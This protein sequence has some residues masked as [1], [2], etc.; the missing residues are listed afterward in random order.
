MS[1]VERLLRTAWA[2]SFALRVWSN[3]NL[4]VIISIASLEQ[5]KTNTN[6][7]KQKQNPKVVSLQPQKVV[8][9]GGGGHGGVVMVVAVVVTNLS[10][11]PTPPRLPRR[12]TTTYDS[13]HYWS[14]ISFLVVNLLAAG[15]ASCSVTI[16]RT[17]VQPNTLI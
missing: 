16:S 7:Q 17:S 14:F 8:C 1:I 11:S 6:K 13:M 15:T 2:S 10:H 12:S 3:K 4:G 5:Q 9:D